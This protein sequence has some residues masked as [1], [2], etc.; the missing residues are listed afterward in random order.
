MYV[1]AHLQSFAAIIFS[2]AV[3]PLRLGFFIESSP[4]WLVIDW[5]TD[6]I[7][8]CDIVVTFRTGYL[9][10]SLNLVTVPSRIRWKYF[11]FWF[12]IDLVSTVPIDKIAGAFIP[13][14]GLRSFKIIRIIRLVRLLK[15]VKLLKID[16]TALEEVVE[17]DAT[18]KKTCS[19]FG[20]LF[21]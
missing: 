2:V 21:V 14:D 5:I 20:F 9:D 6:G 18:V 4:A 16:T 12:L 11:K 13:S 17:V 7:F 3:V 15:L 19:L 10:D 1:A 8:T